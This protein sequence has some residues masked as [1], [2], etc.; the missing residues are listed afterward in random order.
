MSLFHKEN[1]PTVSLPVDCNNQLEMQYRIMR[2]LHGEMIVKYGKPVCVTEPWRQPENWLEKSDE[3]LDPEHP[4]TSLVHRTII[5]DNNPNWDWQVQHALI[6]YLP[7]VTDGIYAARIMP[8][9]ATQDGQVLVPCACDFC[10]PE[11]R[12]R[13]QTEEDCNVFLIDYDRIRSAFSNQ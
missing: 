5:A 9:V 6:R 12:F 2:E 13:E 4:E 10:N 3:L 7:C 11:E 8:M 1:T